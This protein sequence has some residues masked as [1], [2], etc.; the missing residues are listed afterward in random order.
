MQET[1]TEQSFD[2][3]LAMEWSLAMLNDITGTIWLDD[4]RRYDND[5]RETELC[6]S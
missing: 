6:H 2:K 5:H 1:D 4:I 3:V